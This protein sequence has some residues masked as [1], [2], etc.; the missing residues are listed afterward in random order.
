MQIPR[1]SGTIFCVHVLCLLYIN[2]TKYIQNLTFATF[3]LPKSYFRRGE[4][5]RFGGKNICSRQA[6]LAAF[7]PLQMITEHPFSYPS[8]DALWLKRRKYYL[9]TVS[10]LPVLCCRSAMSDMDIVGVGE[11]ED[12]LLNDRS[13]ITQ[14]YNNKTGEPSEQSTF[15]T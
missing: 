6:S 8:Q 15:Q 1:K 10:C 13:P 3:S 2:K 11:E 9:L 4:S 5:R 14:S 7:K 12:D